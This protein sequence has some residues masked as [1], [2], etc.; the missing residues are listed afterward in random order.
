MSSASKGLSLI[1]HGASYNSG[2]DASPQPQSLNLTLLCTDTTSEPKFTSYNGSA[3]NVE[4]STVAACAGDGGGSEDDS[5]GG[6]GGG[7]GEEKEKEKV[8]S[9]IGWFFLV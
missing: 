2:P 8:G 3:L 9:G 4:W 7:S 5:D 1:L 6:S